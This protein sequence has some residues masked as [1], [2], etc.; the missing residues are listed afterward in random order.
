MGLIKLLHDVKVEITSDK[1][2]YHAKCIYL[3]KCM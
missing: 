2:E 3:I 1:L